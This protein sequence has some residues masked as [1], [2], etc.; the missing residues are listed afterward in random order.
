MVVAVPQTSN[1]THRPVTL[2]TDSQV[3]SRIV[4][5]ARMG[6]AVKSEVNWQAVGAIAAA[7][8]AAVALLAFATHENGS[9]TQNSTPPN[10]LSSP[11]TTVTVTVAP[12]GVPLN[13]LPDPCEASTAGTIKSFKLDMGQP[14]NNS[15]E[16]LDPSSIKLCKW[17]VAGNQTYSFFLLSYDTFSANLGP[18][19]SPVSIP[20]VSHASEYRADPTL[21]DVMWNT[22]FGSIEVT[23]GL[24]S[25]FAGQDDP[26]VGVRQWTEALLPNLPT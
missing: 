14:D 20:G 1:Q 18:D 11:N 17:I 4:S 26:C 23:A 9:G 19:S 15:P 6:D 13:S 24:S 3:G 5:L 2:C 22:S 7:V 8:S 12:A 10:Y 25:D 21:C 16:N